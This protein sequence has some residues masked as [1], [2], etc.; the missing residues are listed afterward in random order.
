MYPSRD[1]DTS[2]T[3]LPITN[4]ST[5]TRS[6]VEIHAGLVGRKDPAGEIHRPPQGRP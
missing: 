1:I 6:G 5:A 3:T 4:A 2:S